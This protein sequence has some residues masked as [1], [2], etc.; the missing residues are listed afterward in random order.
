VPERVTA[1]VRSAT[2]RAVK[3]SD[4]GSE[5]KLRSILLGLWRSY[6]EQASELP[7]RPDFVFDDLRLAVFL[8]SDFWHGRHWFERGAAPENN[9]DYWVAK[10]QRNKARDDA[11]TRR[12][13][14]QGWSVVRVWES[15]LSQR[16]MVAAA[17]ADRIRLIDRRRVSRRRPSSGDGRDTRE[18]DDPT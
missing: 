3:S 8:D 15:E 4:T 16:G 2:M 5:Q 11:A 13:R 18:A 12:L 10:F 14:R 9:R 7:G 1:E 17:L 6:R